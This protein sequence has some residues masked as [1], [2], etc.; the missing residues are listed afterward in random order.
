MTGLVIHFVQTFLIKKKHIARLIQK[1]G[2]TWSESPQIEQNGES[3][4]RQPYNSGHYYAEKKKK[5]QTLFPFSDF[6]VS[7]SPFIWR[8]LQQEVRLT[9]LLHCDSKDKNSGEKFYLKAVGTMEQVFYGHTNRSTFASSCYDV[10]LKPAVKLQNCLPVPVVVSQL[11]LKRT[12]TFQPGEMFHLSHLAPNRASIVVMIENYLNK[13]WVCTKNLPEEDVEFSV[14]SFESHDSPSVMTLDL[15]MHNVDQEGIQVLSLYCPFWM[16]NKTGFTLSYRKSK[17]PDKDS[18]TPNKNVDETGNVIFHPK[19]YKE[20][21]L[22]SFKAKNFFGKK[23]ASIRLEFGEWSDKFSLD[24]AGS[25]GVVTCK[26]EGRTY[27]LST[28]IPEQ[29]DLLFKMFRLDD[30]N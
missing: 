5:T 15:G 14:W 11:G 16:L 2:P 4:K 6:T 28:S 7:V 8:E 26:L 12:Q 30:S 17:K 18:G 20:P 3:I 22:F 1:A 9:K 29:P 21:I 23:K 10:V 25:S 13:C 19:D 27:Q 24:V